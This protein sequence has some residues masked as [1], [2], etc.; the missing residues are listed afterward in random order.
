[1]HVFIGIVGYKRITYCGLYVRGY[2]GFGSVR[3]VHHR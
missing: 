3:L 1:M 2:S